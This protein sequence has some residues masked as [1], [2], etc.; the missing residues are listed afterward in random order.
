MSNDTANTIA[1]MIMPSDE[2]STMNIN[3]NRKLSGIKVEYCGYRVF[4]DDKLKLGEIEL[5]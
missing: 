5:R 1:E 2:F 3:S 4:I